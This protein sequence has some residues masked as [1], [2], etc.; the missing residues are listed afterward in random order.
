MELRQLKYFL[1]T[2]Q[3][4]NFSEAARE[5]CITQSTL[6]QQIKQL[7]DEFGVRLFERTS[8]G[9]TLTESGE[10]LIPYADKVLHSAQTCTQLIEDLRNL[11][12]GTLSIG[13]TYSFSPIL[14]ETLLLFARQYPKVKLNVVYLPMEELMDRLQRREVDLVLAFK[15][16]GHRFYNIDSHTLF[17]TYLSVIVGE[18]HS[19]AG[20]ESITLQELQRYT[21]A[22]PAH[23]MQARNSFEWLVKDSLLDFKANVELNSISLLF[24]LVREGNIAT[25]LN[26]AIIFG[27]MGLKAVSIDV[28]CGE[29]S[30]EGCVHVLKDSYMKNSARTFIKM[31]CETES[32]KLR[33]MEW[34]S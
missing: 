18:G 26:E 22:L 9:A 15:P 21:L 2:A 27:E 1:Q 14:T 17:N 16:H 32:T 30:M 4:L 11:A 5:L 24:K 8:H 19:L 10:E 3:T 33:A 7:E 25:V 12:T 34:I 31:L 29:K 20:R 28:P 23:G 6:S 13:V